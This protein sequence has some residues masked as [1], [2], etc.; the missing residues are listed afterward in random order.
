MMWQSAAQQGVGHG[1]HG[2]HVR[3]PHGPSGARRPPPRAQP[4]RNRG[5]GFGLHPGV[6]GDPGS[7]WTSWTTR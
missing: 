3:R 4:R 2:H 5:G 6:R 1:G 7:A